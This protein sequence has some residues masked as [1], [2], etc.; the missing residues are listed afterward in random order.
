MRTPHPG[1]FSTTGR[2]GSFPRG[3]V[4]PAAVVDWILLRMPVP[5]AKME[6]QKFLAWGHNR[7]HAPTCCCSTIAGVPLAAKEFDSRIDAIACERHLSDAILVARRGAIVHSKG[8]DWPAVSEGSP[9][10]RGRVSRSLRL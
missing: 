9:I 2:T 4:R 8:M 5:D 1:E 10:H 6:N 7:N 3:D